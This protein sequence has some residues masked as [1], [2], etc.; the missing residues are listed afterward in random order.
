MLDPRLMHAQ[1]QREFELAHAPA[2]AE[3]ERYRLLL[4]G[5]ASCATSCS[6]CAMHSEL[7]AEALK[8]FRPTAPT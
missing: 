5:I 7:A 1:M 4:G 2:L 8:E 3:L 6:C